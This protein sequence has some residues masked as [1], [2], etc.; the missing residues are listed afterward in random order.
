[1]TLSTQ[2]LVSAFDRRLRRVRGQPPRS[3]DI[4]VQTFAVQ[5]ANLDEAIADRGPA[6]DGA[7][8]SR[9]LRPITSEDGAI[10]SGVWDSTAGRH[11]IC[12]DFDEW[13]HIL[14]GEVHIT[15]GDETRTL[16]AGD[17]A[18]FHAGVHMIW[19]VP[20]YV[21]KVWVQRHR[22]PGLV[23]RAAKHLVKTVR[24]IVKTP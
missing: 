20:R 16:R 14:E 24:S 18:F 7:P 6:S 12:F 4:A 13:V 8:V 21:R 22:R 3:A 9:W 15:V 23:A 11:D 1:M 17:V 5:T 10:E 2:R 19:N